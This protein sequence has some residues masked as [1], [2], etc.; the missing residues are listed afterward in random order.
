MRD[1]TSFKTFAIA[2]SLFATAAKAAEPAAT[3]DDNQETLL[4]ETFDDSSEYPDGATLPSG[5]TSTGTYKFT[6]QRGSYFG[7]NAHS[8]NY[9]FGTPANSGSMTRDELFCT[10][11]L[12][13]KAG[14]E[15]TISFWYKTPG[16]ASDVF[17]T[18][19]LTKVGTQQEYNS[20]SK[21]LG[22]TPA[23]RT[24]EWTQASYKF[25]PDADGEYC[26]GFNLLTILYN[27]GAVVID[28]IS[29][30]GPK[31]DGGLTDPDDRVVCDLPYSQSFDNENNDYD[32]KHYLPNGWMA[33]G[34][35]PF[36]TSNYD[37]L[38][39]KDGEWYAIAPESSIAR[40]DRMYTA[41]FKLQKGV[42]YS[43]KFWLYMPGDNGAASD[44]DFT[45]G[46]EQDSEFH[47]SLLSLPAYTNDAWTEQTVRFT[48][49]ETDFY[50]FSFAT[51]GE[52]ATAGEV[53]IDLF[54]LQAEGQS[55]KP[56][57]AFSYNGYFNLMDSKLVA[58]DN[59][60]VKMINQT[61]DGESYLW[62]AEGAEPETSE[63]V[64]PVFSFPKSGTYNVTLTARN[65][66]GESTTS[67][68]ID[69]T[70]FD[71]DAQQMP[72]AVYN[73][74]EDEL[75]TRD[76]MPAYA[77]NVG[78]DWVTGI[79]HYYTS[80]AER[81]ALPEGKEYT[82]SSI[83]YYLCYYNLGNRYYSKQAAL[84]V[85]VVVYGEKDNRPDLNNVYGTYTTTMKDAFGT[86][87]LS[88]AEMRGMPLPEPITA[89]GPFYLAFEFDKDVWI[90]EPDGNL[91]RTAVGF[92][93]FKHR[94]AETTF[95]VQPHATPDGCTYTVDGNYCPVDSIDSEYKG[96]GLNV[97]AWMSVAQ[98][99]T[100]LVAVGADGHAAF[101][102][103]LDGDLLT[104]S[105]TAK[106]DDIAVY[107]A[108]GNMVAKTKA[109]DLST[110]VT[111]NVKPGVYVVA[112]K[113]GTRKFVKK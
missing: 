84:P 19:I 44:F 6:R 4:E 31:D 3:A 85:K 29:V 113:A 54:T 18:Q 111:L 100:A 25:T 61:T 14:K 1:F 96:V 45:V 30:S 106:G 70:L 76:N 36:V 23:V 71:N 74:N 41:F 65:A 32:G 37:D 13:M 10:K 95:Y 50:C 53:C 112:T 51:G 47:T 12:K 102:T 72:V 57:A 49:E 110:A 75:W 78:A 21:T 88:K 55:P 108:S 99:T 79:N 103:R 66:S 7:L 58:F 90:D 87:G 60:K 68:E 93:G 16:G 28:D 73:P 69:V 82:L 20:M 107:D 59:T 86:L 15:Y 42:T 56:R 27:S 105:G 48:P 5:W 109:S 98:G 81:F 104:V 38:K 91:S 101:A 24:S 80:F 64:N 40:D 83:S 11:K 94:S 92:G 67:E 35:S 63:E 26:F 17:T 33:T 89:K 8:G 34:T 2:L 52:S 43:A 9:V 97:V 22:E 62:T 46:T 77:T 39:A